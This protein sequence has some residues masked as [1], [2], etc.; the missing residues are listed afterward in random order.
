MAKNRRGYR[1]CDFSND[2]R[3]S[4]SQ[5][6]SYKYDYIILIFPR[7]NMFSIQLMVRSTAGAVGQR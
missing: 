7:I 6:G 4:P 5:L 3:R 1:R 2:L